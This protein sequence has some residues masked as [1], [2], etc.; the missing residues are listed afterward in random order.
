MN[1]TYAKDMFRSHGHRTTRS[2]L[3]LDIQKP[4]KVYE[5][6][7]STQIKFPGRNNNNKNPMYPRA[8]GK[9]MDFSKLLWGFWLVGC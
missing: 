2:K 3:L 7:S 9:S 1:L 4:G 5:F 8:L 6:F